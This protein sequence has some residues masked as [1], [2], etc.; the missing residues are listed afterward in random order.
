VPARPPSG[1]PDVSADDVDADWGRADPVG[2]EGVG[3]TVSTPDQDIVD[4]IGEA[5]GVTYRDGEE[6]DPTEKVDRRDVNTW[7]R[8]LDPATESDYAERQ[9]RLDSGELDKEDPDRE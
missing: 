6:L 9:R 4:E 1:S 8:R 2:E 5:A 7:E 3:G